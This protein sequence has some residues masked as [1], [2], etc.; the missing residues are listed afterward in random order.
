MIRLLITLLLLAPYTAQS[1]AQGEGP[2][3]ERLPN[4]FPETGLWSP[5]DGSKTGIFFEVQDGLVFGALFGFDSFGDDVW[6]IFSGELTPRS[7]D[8]VFD[9]D[10]PVGWLIEAELVRFLSGGCVI[11]CMSGDTEVDPSQLAP[12]TIRVEFSGRNKAI[13]SIAGG[14]EKMLVPLPFGVDAQAYDPNQPSR[15]LPDLSGAWV[16]ASASGHVLNAGPGSYGTSSIVELGEAV[17]TPIEDSTTNP[18]AL[19]TVSFPI[20]EDTGGLF[21]DEAKFSCRFFETAPDEPPARPNCAVSFSA[22]PMEGIRWSFEN[23]SDSRLTAFELS[24]VAGSLERLEL[25]RLDYD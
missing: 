18:P 9:P 22:G 8:E 1:Y 19:L 15:F 11:D 13:Y 24:D 5:L 23:V 3:D 16:V 2:S 4:P 14:P 25:F 12:G 21:P 7:D 6:A 10:P 17:I 20:V